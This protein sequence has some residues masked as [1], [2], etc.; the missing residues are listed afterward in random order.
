[1]KNISLIIVL[2]CIFGCN[3]QDKNYQRAILKADSLEN[4]LSKYKEQYGEIS[5]ILKSNG[6]YGI[7]KIGNY[8]DNFGEIKDEKYISTYVTGIFSNSATTNSPLGV[9]LIIDKKSIRF[10]LYEYAREHPIKG[11]GMIKFEVKDGS[12]KIHTIYTSNT[13]GGDNFV[14]EY[15][16]DCLKTVINILLGNGE[17][18]FYGVTLDR[19]ISEYKFTI[20]NTDFLSEALNDI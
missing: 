18:K 16:N 10:Q 12:G 19:P 2:I 8:I 20:K 17:I 7:W 1:M 5:T 13:D 3:I 11:K 6:K 15:T 14:F 9:L 4:E